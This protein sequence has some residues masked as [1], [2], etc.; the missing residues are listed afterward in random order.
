MSKF[1]K[2]FIFGSVI[3]ELLPYLITQEAVKKIVKS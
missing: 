1:L 2:G 3:G